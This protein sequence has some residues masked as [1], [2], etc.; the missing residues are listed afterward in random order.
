MLLLTEIQP[1]SQNV[2]DIVAP[3]QKQDEPRTPLKFSPAIWLEGEDASVPSD[4][5]GD[6]L[7]LQNYFDQSSNNPPIA[8][9]G[10]NEGEDG[11]LDVENSFDLDNGR[12]DDYVVPFNGR[13][14]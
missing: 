7:N 12:T 10:E 6:E 11:N 13:Q 3:S 9:L 4:N 14:Q 8:V 5:N 1:N 2:I